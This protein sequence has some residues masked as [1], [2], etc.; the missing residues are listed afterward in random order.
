MPCVE[1]SQLNQCPC[2]RRTWTFFSI[3]CED[4]VRRYQ[5]ASIRHLTL[6][7]Q[8][9]ESKEELLF[10]KGIYSDVILLLLP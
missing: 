10:K 7:S 5:K 2:K 3:P 1:L 9:P 4:T 6:A 8:I